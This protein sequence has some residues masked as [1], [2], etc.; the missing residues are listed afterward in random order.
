MELLLINMFSFNREYCES[1]Q[2]NVEEAYEKLEE[3]Q[4]LFVG[5]SI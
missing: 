2:K 4:N 3:Y 1:L 5:L